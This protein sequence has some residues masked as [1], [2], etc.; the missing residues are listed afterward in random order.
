MGLDS[1]FI[2]TSDLEEY[3]VDKDSGAP[4]AAGIVTFYKD[5]DRSVKKPVYQLT[6]SPPNYSYS[7]L[8]NPCILS[9][10]GTFQDGGGNNIVAYYFPYEGTPDDSDGTVE[11][12]YITVESSGLIPQFTREGWPNFTSN[13][14]PSQ[15]EGFR[16]FIPNGQFLNHT[17][18]VGTSQPPIE[19]VNGIDIQYIAQGGWTFRRT[20]GGASIF[21]NSFSRITGA[22][23]GINDFPRYAFNFVCSS[24]NA[25]DQTR[26]LSIQWQGINQFSSGDPPGSQSYTFFFSGESND[27]STY[28][29]DVRLI[30]DYGTGGSPSPQS[31][32]S[33][34]TIIIGPGYSTKILSIINI[35]V[36]AGTLGTNDDD[37]VAIALRGPS[38]SWNV[39][40]TDFALLTGDVQPEFFPVQTDA[41]MKARGIAGWMPIPNPDGSDLYLAPVLTPR[42]MVFDHS[43]VGKIYANGYVSGFTGSLADDTNE[44]LCDGS[45]YTVT[46]YSP[47]GI[48]Y[49]RLWNK[50]FDTGLVLPIYGTGFDFITSYYRGDIANVFTFTT[51]QA[52]SQ[53]ATADGAIPTGFTISTLFTGNATY[54]LGSFISEPGNVIISFG[55]T[56]GTATAITA[57]T[58]GFGVAQNLDST[59]VKQLFTISVGA[60]P[61]AGSYFTFDIVGGGPFYVWF[62]I[63]GAG[64]DPAPGGTGILVPL[65]AAYSTVNAAS[66]IREAMS[67]YQGTNMVTV[68]AG[69]IPA[70]AYFTF[71]ANGNTYAVWYKVAGLGTA[72]VIAGETIEV[73]LM[74]TE[75]AAQVAV[76]SVIAINSYRFAVPNTKGCFLRGMNVGQS[77][78]PG[79]PNYTSRFNLNDVFNGLLNGIGSYQFNEL[80]QHLHLYDKSNAITSRGTPPEVGYLEDATLLASLPRVSTTVTDTG[81]TGGAEERPF[82]MYVSYVIKY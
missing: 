43:A 51:N 66:L 36:A 15:N 53:T 5:V 3:F 59:L 72:P 16:N 39:Q 22:V 82:N 29:F 23:S 14:T 68:A 47:I 27:A 19:V 8:P 58:S 35:P 79:D 40:V 41:D 56:A 81:N 50:I 46:D 61:A 71:H 7:A 13:D 64:V 76:A 34:G 31:D 52:G 45:S 37:Y 28:T 21:N 54:G 32:T 38:S 63:N 2:V 12:Y 10:V 48:P 65:L 6:G 78:I 57:G 24:F 67:G 77:N 55:L 11:L 30:R 44:I 60:L 17:Q 33:I 42:G 26:D 70:G 75:T 4:L 49:S 74:G 1:R 69:A 9:A 25:S 18:I 80:I 20:N 62:T 73:D